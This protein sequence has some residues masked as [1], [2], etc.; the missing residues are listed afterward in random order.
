MTRTGFT[1]SETMAGPFAMGETEPQ[2]GATSDSRLT[3]HA[4]IDIDDLDRFV[5]DANHTGRL[6]GRVEFPPLG[7]EVRAET[8]VFNLFSPATAP[9]TKLMVYELALPGYYLAGKKHV[10]DGVGFD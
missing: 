2:R 10:H 6:S 5:A 1:F 3:M 7:G 8:G 4:T 9:G